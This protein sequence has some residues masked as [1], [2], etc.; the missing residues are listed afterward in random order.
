M[1]DPIADMLTRI[2]NAYAV[3][4]KNVDV[5]Y[6]KM[7]ENIASVLK[8]EGYIN[9]YE[10]KG[11]SPKFNLAVKLAYKGSDPVVSKIERVSKPG[12]RVYIKAKY[13]KPVLGGY[14]TAVVSTSQGVVTDKEAKAK[15]LGGEVICRV[16]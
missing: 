15:G 9:S 4:L 13:I 10:K 6:S 12:R 7:K 1:T 5:P 2:R 14:G 3:G 8:K 11:E 16:W